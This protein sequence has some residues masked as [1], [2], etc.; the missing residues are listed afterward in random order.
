MYSRHITNLTVCCLVSAFQWV[1]SATR[2]MLTLRYEKESAFANPLNRKVLL[3]NEISEVMLRNGYSVPGHLC[4]AKYR[5]LLTTY[6]KV[7]EKV[8]EKGSSFVRWE[9]FELMDSHL[10]H[11]PYTSVKY[12]QVVPND[13]DQAREDEEEEEEEMVLEEEKEP[14]LIRGRGRKR[15]KLT[16]SQYLQNKLRADERK[17]REYQILEEKRLK[18]EYKKLELEQKKIDVLKSLVVAL[19]QG[20]KL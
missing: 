3:W 5:N 11:I 10:G 19:K 12:S 20:K 16:I 9:F 18:L 4:D 6:R 7:K 8:K 15:P 2:L 17:R 14:S 1:P 13:V